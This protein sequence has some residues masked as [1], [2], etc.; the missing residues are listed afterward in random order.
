MLT[1]DD[2]LIR[3]DW[4]LATTPKPLTECGLHERVVPVGE[5]V[6]AIG[7]YSAEKGGIVPGVGRGEAPVR[8]L[9]GTAPAVYGQ[10]KARLRR[11]LVGALVM[12]LV[13]NGG[14][15]LLAAR[16]VAYMEP[17]RRSSSTSALSGVRL[18]PV[19]S[20]TGARK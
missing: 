8:L 17:K 13:V 1:D 14:L 9:R 11:H 2:G 7:P 15:F 10:L 16:Y 4:Q 5:M 18:S 19:E 20:T 3:K 12:I 6:V